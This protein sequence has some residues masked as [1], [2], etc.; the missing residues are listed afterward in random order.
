[1]SL[2]LLL[3]SMLVSTVL[4]I[5]VAIVTTKLTHSGAKAIVLALLAGVSSILTEWLATPEGFNWVVWGI[6]YF[7]QF[8]VAV[9]TH[10]GLWKP[11]GVA[12][13]VQGNVGRT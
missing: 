8:L 6:L 13:T 10:F 2:T 12:E 5:L 9:A 4:P 11:T 3:I 1:M 7:Q